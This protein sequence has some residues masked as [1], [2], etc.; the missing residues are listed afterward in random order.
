MCQQVNHVKHTLYNVLHTGACL[1]D[2]PSNSKYWTQQKYLWP[3][4][5]LANII[6]RIQPPTKVIW[7][8]E[9]LAQIPYKRTGRH[10]WMHTNKL[11]TC[12]PQITWAVLFIMNCVVVLFKRHTWE[13]NVQQLNWVVCS[14]KIR[15]YILHMCMYK[16]NVILL[17]TMQNQGQ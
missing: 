8:E 17:Q 9:E 14:R 11:M 3:V 1:L 12:Y 13:Y 4:E 7:S 2:H 6:C 15:R 16:L 5:L 10:Y